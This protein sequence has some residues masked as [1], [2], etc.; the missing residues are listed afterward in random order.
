M[1][2]GTI[3]ILS[4][5]GNVVWSCGWG[6]LSLISSALLGAGGGTVGGTFGSIYTCVI[7]YILGLVGLG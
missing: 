7:N 6:I 2:S 3:Y 5:M 4:A 1:V